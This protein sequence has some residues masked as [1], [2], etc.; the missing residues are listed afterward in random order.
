MYVHGRVYVLNR[1]YKQDCNNDR[2]LI[3]EHDRYIRNALHLSCQFGTDESIRAQEMV[4]QGRLPM[5]HMG[6]DAHVADVRYTLSL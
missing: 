4:A 1:R 5:I 2:E 3:V 6:Q